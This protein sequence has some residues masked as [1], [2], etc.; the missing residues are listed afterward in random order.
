M[1][2]ENQSQQSEDAR[3]SGP[4]PSHSV[5]R[6][7]RQAHRP[8]NVAF[9]PDGKPTEAFQAKVRDQQGGGQKLPEKA[10]APTAAPVSAPAST[11]DAPDPLTA[12]LLAS[13]EPAATKEPNVTPGD[14]PASGSDSDAVTSIVDRFLKERFPD[15]P[16]QN[17]SENATESFRK[18]KD[19]LK[20]AITTGTQQALQIDA[21]QR[22]RDKLAAKIQGGVVVP[23]TEAVTTLQKQMQEYQESVKAQIER[24]KELE[25]RYSLETNPEF[26]T[27]YDLPRTQLRESINAVAAEAG[28]NSAVVDAALSKKSELSLAKYLEGEVEDGTARRILTDKALQ[29]QKLTSERDAAVKSSSKED[30]LSSLQ[31]YKKQEEERAAKHAQE[32]AATARLKGN[33]VLNKLVNEAATDG[34]RPFWRTPGAA[35]VV[36]QV[37]SLIDTDGFMSVEGVIGDKLRA[38]EGESWKA[39]AAH[40]LNEITELRQQLSKYVKVGTRSTSGGGGSSS[41]DSG[42]FRPPVRGARGLKDLKMVPMG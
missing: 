27:K 22:E 38:A 17:A 33:E 23:E 24:A 11:Q 28:V 7:G 37:K 9:G 20:A 3:N 13:Q 42:S 10:S 40:Q 41:P 12:A 39:L 15:R 5:R 30:V 25:A 6:L 8:K 34:Q 2:E 35:Q 26:A 14:K 31:A 21:I 16:A 18:V 1:S 4:E 36:S 29:F 32:R 19:D